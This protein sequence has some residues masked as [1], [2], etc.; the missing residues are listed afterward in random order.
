MCTVL[1][2]A[3]MLHMAPSLG[4]GQSNA[5]YFTEMIPSDSTFDSPVAGNSSTLGNH[6]PLAT[7]YIDH[8]E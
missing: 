5:L 1:I 8:N 2:D 6:L 3:S 7:C 4:R